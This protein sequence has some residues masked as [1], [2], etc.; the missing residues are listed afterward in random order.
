MWLVATVADSTAI[1]LIRKIFLT[2]LCIESPG[3][4]RA[5]ETQAC[6]LWGGPWLQSYQRVCKG[7]SLFQKPRPR[8][9]LDT[10]HSCRLAGGA[11]NS[12]QFTWNFPR[13][14]TESPMFWE[15]HRCQAHG[16]PWSPWLPAA[17]KDNW[18]WDK[19]SSGAISGANNSIQRESSLS[20]TPSL[21]LRP[22]PIICTL[23]NHASCSVAP[24]SC[25]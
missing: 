24:Q 3:T 17:A 18:Q 8:D 21:R 19:D 10:K 15:R 25:W 2:E 22:R 14:S 4:P 5:P 7:L 12:S 23:P 9:L 1:S 16:D 6:S 20:P 11:T 13:C